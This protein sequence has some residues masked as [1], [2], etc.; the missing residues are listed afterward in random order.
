M[1]DRRD[2]EDLNLEADALNET[3]GQTSALVTGFDTELRR[4]KVSLG[5]ARKDV[6]GLERGLGRG[7]RSAI[8]GVLLD[9]E[10]FS[11]AM[12][13]VRNSIISATYNAAIRPV[14]TGVG[15][16]I[17]S[18]VGGLVQSI[19]P[20]ANGAPFSQGRVMPFASGGI[21]NGT[22]P[23]GMRG[24]VGVMGEAGPEAIMPLARGPDGKL[25]VRGAGGGSGTTVVMNISTPDVQSFQRSQGQIAAQMTRVLSRGQRNR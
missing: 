9:G 17:A 22:T 18:G 14:T 23:F 12:R 25:G 20:F 21:V 13:T 15:D 5:G 8:D 4:M 19:L 24:G 7:L 1:T 2:I 10:R 6:A 11:D 16:A 3:L